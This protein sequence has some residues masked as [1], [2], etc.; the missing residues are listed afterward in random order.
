MVVEFSRESILTQLDKVEVHD[1]LARFRLDVLKKTLFKKFLPTQAH[2]DAQHQDAILRFLENNQKCSQYTIDRVPVDLLNYV[3]DE[4]ATFFQDNPEDR[5]SFSLG[6]FANYGLCG[7]GSSR[8]AKDTSMF[9][10]MFNSSL[11][12]TSKKLYTVYRAVLS[13]RWLSAET[14]RHS[15]HSLKIGMGSRFTTVPKDELRR[16]GICVEPTLNMFFQ[17]GCKR[18]LDHQL[19]AKF[20]MNKADQQEINRRLARQGSINQSYCTIDLKDASDL[21]PK[22]LLNHIFPTAVA[23]VLTDMRSPTFEIDGAIHDM[24][25]LSSMGNGFTFP[26]MTLLISSIVRSVYRLNGIHPKNGK[27]YAVWGD[28]IVTINDLYPQI[29][30]ALKSFNFIINEDKSFS[31]GFFR[32]SCG[33]DYLRGFDVRGVYIKELKNE[34]HFYSSCNR[35]LRWSL[36][37][38]IDISSVIG[39]LLGYT[40]LRFVPPYMPADSG[41]IVPR[42]SVWFL[43]RDSNGSIRFK[44]L[45][46]VPR[47]IRVKADHGLNYDGAVICAIH[48]SIQGNSYTLRCDNLKYKV[49]KVISPNWEVGSDN[50]SPWLNSQEGINCVRRSLEF[51]TLNA[52]E[53][54]IS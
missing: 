48:G 39:T 23:S 45:S 47:R 42:S 5:A 30:F 33:G 36:H 52:L 20:N 7:P 17:L 11:D 21:I 12:T 10:K 29:I 27:N 13:E 26:I 14:F 40:K 24:E 50:F 22:Q 43:P 28:D 9:T 18:W 44:R 3:R 6:T 31:A 35:L 2:S 49:V 15:H 1:D 37:T 41:F 51:R 32:E 16:R 4:L 38:G 25:M 34:G 53:R 46:P 8:G 54:L 19:L